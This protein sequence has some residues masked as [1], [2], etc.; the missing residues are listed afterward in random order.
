MTHYIKYNIIN[1]G[2]GL[3]NIMKFSY[4]NI[5]VFL[6]KFFLSILVIVLLTYI[7]IYLLL[8]FLLNR[9]DY[10]QKITETVKNQTGLV[11]IIKNYKI[12]VSPKL[13]ITIK[14][15][16]INLFYP[17]KKQIL[18]INKGE[19]NV[20]S[21]YLLKKEIKINK[22]KADKFQFSTKLLKDNQTSI[23]AYIEKNIKNK[24]KTFTLSKNTPKILS[25]DCA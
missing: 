18:S 19:F 13:E 2:F 20:S 9:N 16:E 1:I 21:L 11:L 4:K 15:D 8:P 12:N 24:D 17:D 22:I 25:A 14:A 5:F 23:Q 7:A 3:Q 10:S 6:K